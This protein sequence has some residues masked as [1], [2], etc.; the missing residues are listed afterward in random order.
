MSVWTFLETSE[1]SKL[2][3]DNLSRDIGRTEQAKGCA[4]RP[5][6]AR[7]STDEREGAPPITMILRVVFCWSQLFDC[8]C[9]CIDC[10]VMGC[11]VVMLLLF[12]MILRG[13]IEGVAREGGCRGAALGEGSST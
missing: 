7:A 3:R 10:Y 12:T 8:M 1:S 13:E 5:S 2:S 11:V 9:Y 4:V 6:P